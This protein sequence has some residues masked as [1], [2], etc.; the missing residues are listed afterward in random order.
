MVD[1]NL[2]LHDLSIV[3]IIKNEGPYLKEWLDYHLV[4]GVD[5][6]YLYDNESPDNQREITA[7]YVKAGIVDYID[8]PGKVMQMVV[9]NDAV[10]R[11]KFQSRLM[12]FIDGDEFLYPKTN[13]SIV[14]VVDEILSHDANAAGLAI[15]W[16]SFGS[17]GQET[18]DYSRGV[19]ERF[20]RRA[21]EN[22]NIMPGQYKVRSQSNIHLKVVNNPRK[23]NYIADPH[24][25]YYFSNHYSILENGTRVPLKNL[26]PSINP[27]VC[28]EKIAVNH[29]QTKS[30]EE[31]IAKIKRGRPEGLNNWLHLEMFDI[32]DRNEVFDD[33]ILKY[34]AER[35]KTYQPP[36]K[37]HADEHLLNALIKNLSPTFL[38]T[39][40]P[41]FYAGK[42]ETFLTCRAVA[43]YLQSKLTDSTPAKFF[44]EAAL[45]AILRSFGVMNFADARLFL[46]E[47]PKLL[48]L[49]YPVVKDIR[50]VALSLIRQLK[51]TF[52]M[53]IMWRDYIEFD[54]LQDLL[55]LIKEE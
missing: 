17:N 48:S 46:R 45:K 28:V 36:D 54:Y 8:A 5:H 10:K 43:T 11:F 47:L 14:E 44:E 50:Q 42:T 55:K 25:A 52:H 33:G 53:N 51:N 41:S 22:W 3:A 37:S 2:F 23:V 24:F 18:A 34:R 38:P 16:Q 40:P 29:Y 4:A 27:N 30:K 9:Y 49:P 21:P 20:T 39:T 35:M 7:P 12:A 13:Q 32:H 31:F 26:P 6:F 1:R 15:H 19:L